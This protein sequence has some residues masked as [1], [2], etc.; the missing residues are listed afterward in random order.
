MRKNDIVYILKNGVN[1]YELRHSLRSVCENF[2]Y[3]RIWFYG[4][5]PEGITADVQ[6]KF[7]QSGNTKFKRAMSTYKEIMQNDE[8]TE[9]FWLFNDDFFIW[10]KITEYEPVYVGNLANRIKNIEARHGCS[11]QYTL[12]LRAT[13]QELRRHG[14]DT[15]DYG[16]HCPILIN[17]KKGLEVLKLYPDC[18]FRSAYGNHCHI[19]G[20]QV[21]DYKIQ[22]LRDYPDD[23]EF[24]STSDVSFRSGNVGKCIRSKFCD[25]CKYETDLKRR[26][27]DID[28]YE[29]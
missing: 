27:A 12:M 4:G 2:P 11:T 21:K 29:E 22:N 7:E 19:G 6:V 8:I 18:S 5:A 10:Q 23:R 26:E 1:P 15:L 24:V 25:P 28:G 9:D 13:L 14:L 16:A 3:K 17:R 20:K